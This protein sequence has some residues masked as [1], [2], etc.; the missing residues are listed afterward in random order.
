MDAPICTSLLGVHLRSM[1]ASARVMDW[2]SHSSSICSIAGRW[3]S[4]WEMTLRN[5]LLTRCILFG[6]VLLHMA[7][8]AGH[9]TSFRAGPP[10]ASTCH[11]NWWRTRT[12]PSA[13]CGRGCVKGS[14]SLVYWMLDEVLRALLDCGN[15]LLLGYLR[16]LR[17][18]EIT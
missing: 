18:D 3:G 16:L 9:S 6:C 7:I 12:Q 4:C 8:Q 1:D 13:Y 5:S 15:E 2:I 17:M 14:Y 11:Q 10:C